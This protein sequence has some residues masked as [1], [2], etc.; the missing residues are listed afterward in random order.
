MYCDNFY[1]L[2]AQYRDRIAELLNL[3]QTSNDELDGLKQ[4]LEDTTRR[5]KPNSQYQFHLTNGRYHSQI[6]SYSSFKGVVW[7]VNANPI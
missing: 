1:L 6:F 3:L 4:K 7:L 5:E 2:T